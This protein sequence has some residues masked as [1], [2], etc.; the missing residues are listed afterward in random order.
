MWWLAAGAVWVWL[1][2][3]SALT[4]D[5]ADPP[6]VRE[7]SRVDAD[8]ARTLCHEIELNAAA[9]EVWPLFATSDGLRTWMAPVAAIDPRAGGMMETSYTPGARIGDAG[10]ILNR[11]EAIQSGERLAI[12]IARA[13]PGFPH[14]D[15]AA[16]LRTLIELEPI[17][18]ARTRVRVTMRGYRAG[19]GFDVLYRHFSAGNAWTLHKLEER[20][21]TGPVDWSALARGETR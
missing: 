3:A 19:E 7:C 18:T 12:S 14:A 16:E 13:P 20:V 6:Q 17:D 2:A 8:G 1:G 15:N 10:N 11:I 5:A 9:N 4:L 21:R